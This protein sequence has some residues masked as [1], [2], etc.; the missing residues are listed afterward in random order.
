MVLDRSKLSHGRAGGSQQY[1]G[2]DFDNTLPDSEEAGQREKFLGE[3]ERERDTDGSIYYVHSRT[4]EATW[5]A[6]P[7]AYELKKLPGTVAT[8]SL[9]LGEGVK[10]EQPAD[11]GKHAKKHTPASRPKTGPQIRR[12]SVAAAAASHGTAMVSYALAS[13]RKMRHAQENRQKM[14]ERVQKKA[15]AK[16]ARFKWR[17]THPGDAMPDTIAIRM[18]PACLCDC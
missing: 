17:L 11:D 8:Y 6:P 13:F 2:G 4:G 15:A 9:V 16:E 7:G 3:W 5:T 1:T 10:S 18:C 12:P 14:V